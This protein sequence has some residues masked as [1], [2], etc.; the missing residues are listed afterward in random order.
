M[1]KMTNY[2]REKLG[3]N[4]HLSIF[5]DIAICNTFTPKIKGKIVLHTYMM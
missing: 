1:N 2:K 3:E 5:H 4:G